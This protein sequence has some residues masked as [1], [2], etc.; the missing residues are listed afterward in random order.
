MSYPPPPGPYPPPGPPP[1]PEG[2]PGGPPGGY[3]PPG[4]APA[5]TPPPAPAPPPQPSYTAPP[6]AP[7][8]PR[9]PIGGA[10][11]A[12]LLIIAGVLLLLLADLVGA[13]TA[14]ADGLGVDFAERL[15]LLGAAGGGFFY[16]V[17]TVLLVTILIIAALRLR[18]SSPGQF[19]GPILMGALIASA[20]VTL[21]V[22]LALIGSFAADGLDPRLGFVLLLLGALV[23]SAGATWYAFG[24][25]QTSRPARPVQPS[26]PQS[27]PQAYQ[28]APPPPSPPPPGYPPPG[29]PPPQG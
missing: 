12:A 14:G 21:F 5:P 13:F 24:E 10:H 4:Y 9:T 23:I 16:S 2:Q 11:L 17:P 22:F 15:F 18:E 26:Y 27:Y 8:P 19:D 28:P 29:Y 25:Y 20:I 1:G 7:A 6:P 3:P